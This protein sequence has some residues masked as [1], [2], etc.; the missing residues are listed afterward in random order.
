MSA[1]SDI[2]TT[3]CTFIRHVTQKPLFCTQILTKFGSRL[4]HNALHEMLDVLDLV[5]FLPS[6]LKNTMTLSNIEYEASYSDHSLEFYT[7]WHLKAAI[8]HSNFD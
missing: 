4:A 3:V 6:E 8:L 2:V 5:S 7:S 1:S